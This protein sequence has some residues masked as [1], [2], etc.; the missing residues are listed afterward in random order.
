MMG[1]DDRRSESRV[2]FKVPA[3]VL[4][5]QVQEKHKGHVMNMSESGALIMMPKVH[6]PGANVALRFTIPPNT[7]CEARGM[8]ARVDDMGMYQG[9]GISLPQP[10][11]AYTIFLRNLA[12][13]EKESIRFIVRDMGRITVWIW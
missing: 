4:V 9:I 1:H 3:H 11:T 12:V 8:I 6:L 5:G 13:A 2:G 7:V 10:N